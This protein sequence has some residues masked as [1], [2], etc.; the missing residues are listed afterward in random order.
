[1]TTIHCNSSTFVIIG[2]FQK[3][4]PKGSSEHS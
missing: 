4:G 2:Y 3:E 1:M